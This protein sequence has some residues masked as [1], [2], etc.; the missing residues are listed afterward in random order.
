MEMIL[1]IS[2]YKTIF[3]VGLFYMVLFTVPLSLLLLVFS[4]YMSPKRNKITTIV[5]TTI[6]TILFIS[7]LVYQR[8]FYTYYTLYSAGKAGQVFEFW[9]EILV[10]VKNNLITILLFFI[11]LI[12]LIIVGNKKFWIHKTR[13]N[14][15]VILAGAAVIAQF[16]TVGIVLN[17]HKGDISSKYLYAETFMP[18]MA[19]NR[20][21]D[22]K[23]V[24]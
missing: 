14:V 18:D 13:R 12:V 1:K 23:S 20:F 21:G 11:P 4:T 16:I 17:D 19:V 8:I 22:R 2:I 3:N 15:K 10:T 7:Q 6:I 9:R 24:V 5:L